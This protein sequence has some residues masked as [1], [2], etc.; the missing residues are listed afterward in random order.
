MKIIV[1]N[2]TEKRYLESILGVLYEADVLAEVEEIQS[3]LEPDERL[4]VAQMRLAHELFGRYHVPVEVD[5]GEPHH[6]YEDGEF[7]TGKC[8]LCGTWTQGVEEGVDLSVVSV[9]EMFSDAE[10]EKWLCAECYH[11]N[12]CAECGEHFPDDQLDRSEDYPVC[13]SCMAK[14]GDTHD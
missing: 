7:V 5:S 2:E 14:D 3:D 12:R 1:N 6:E 4:S 13:K 8:R 9:D 10:Q 11:N